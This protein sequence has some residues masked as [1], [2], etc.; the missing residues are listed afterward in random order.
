MGLCF[1][2]NVSIFIPFFGGRVF[3]RDKFLLFW[4]IFPLDYDGAFPLDAS[5]T[6]GI[7]VRHVIKAPARIVLRD[8]H[9][10]RM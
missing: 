2:K 4:P 6:H 9:F 5:V 3:W 10:A 1:W 7:L 8:G